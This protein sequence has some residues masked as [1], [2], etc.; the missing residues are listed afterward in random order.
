MPTSV[1]WRE[2]GAVCPIKNQGSCGSCWA[3]SAVGALEGAY[4][5]KTG[6]LVCF[7]EQQLVDCAKGIHYPGFGCNGGYMDSAFHYW[8]TN[9]AMTED[10]YPYKGKDQTCSYDESK[11]IVNV[12]SF[13]FV[14][15][16]DYN[17]LMGAIVGQ[18][19]ST[20]IQ[21][22][23][24]VFQ[25]YISGVIDSPNCGTNLDHGV[26]LVGYGNDDGDYYILKN[27]W[28][29]TWGEK[30]YFRIRNQRL[31]DQGICGVQMEP[32][33]PVL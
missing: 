18:P 15:P 26:L 8:K 28:G 19:V 13:V 25:S 24:P 14:K 30:G 6:N 32:S 7:S 9:S 1:D 10:N 11:G 17:A 29:V 4:E 33:Y 31:N 12:P 5:I 23:K 3:F 21:A 22:N 20:G 27:S 16:K 2:Q